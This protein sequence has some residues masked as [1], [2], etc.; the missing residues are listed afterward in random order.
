[1]VSFA[2]AF[3]K[4]VIKFTGEIIIITIIIIITTVYLKIM[5]L[6]QL[7][8]FECADTTS[9]EFADRGGHK[10]ICQYPD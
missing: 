7:Q 3:V 1:V 9:E 5:F 2:V 4:P 8:K 10:P 6:L